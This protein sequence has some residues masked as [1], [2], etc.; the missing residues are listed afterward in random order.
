VNTG[1]A[2]VIFILFALVGLALA[3]VW[4]TR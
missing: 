2:V 4:W 1:N 3:I